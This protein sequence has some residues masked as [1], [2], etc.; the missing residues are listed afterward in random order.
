MEISF[1]TYQ[2]IYNAT[3]FALSRDNASMSSDELALI[4]AERIAQYFDI[5]GIDYV[6]DPTPSR[7]IVRVFFADDEDESE[8]EDE[9]EDED[10]YDDC[11]Y[12]IGYDPYVEGF[13]D[14]C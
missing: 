7:K 2:H 11:D 14:D 6:G 10:D 8:D 4:T 5:A 1:D 13:T 3:Y 9:D 12:E